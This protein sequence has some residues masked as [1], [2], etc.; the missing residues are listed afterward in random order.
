LAEGLD[1]EPVDAGLEVGDGDVAG[2]GEALSFLEEE[3]VGPGAARRGRLGR[4]GEGEP[5]GA[6]AAKVPLPS[7]S[8]RSPPVPPKP[9]L[10][11]A[12]VPLR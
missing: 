11:A 12:L 9:R 7:C 1:H 5:V 4:A 6:V 3:E 10:A 8:N 2:E